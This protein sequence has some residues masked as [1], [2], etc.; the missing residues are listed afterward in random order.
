MSVKAVIALMVEVEVDVS[1][2]EIMSASYLPQTKI[3]VMGIQAQDAK[4]NWVD[5]AVA[6]PPPK[7]SSIDEAEEWMERN[8]GSA[9]AVTIHPDDFQIVEQNIAIFQPS[10]WL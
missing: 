9:A 8:N 1:A 6:V 10:N 5:A 3:A 2:N 4:G 7:F